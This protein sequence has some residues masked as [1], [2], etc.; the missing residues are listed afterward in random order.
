MSDGIPDG[1]FIAWH[2]EGEQFAGIWQ[3]GSEQFAGLF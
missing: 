2:A 3:T 1:D